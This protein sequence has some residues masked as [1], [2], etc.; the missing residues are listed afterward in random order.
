[1]KLSVKTICRTLSFEVTRNNTIKELRDLILN[2]KVLPS[3]SKFK[4]FYL[5]EEM[6]DHKTLGDYYILDEDTIYLEYYL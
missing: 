4:L 6:I 3:H 5:G 1:M 2:N